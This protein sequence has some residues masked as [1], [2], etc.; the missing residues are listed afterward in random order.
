MLD[1]ESFVYILTY[2]T[3]LHFLDFF[4]A[5]EDGTLLRFPPIGI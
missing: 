5:R 1:C 4:A 3:R 2:A